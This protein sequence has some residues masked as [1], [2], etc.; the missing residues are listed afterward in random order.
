MKSEGPG[1]GATLSVILP[2][3]SKS[4]QSLETREELVAVVNS[5]LNSREENRPLCS[6][7]KSQRISRQDD[8]YE[9]FAD[10]EPSIQELMRLELPRF[11][12]EVSICLDGATAL[13]V[14]EQSEFD[15]VVVDLDMPGGRT[16]VIRRVRELFGH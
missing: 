3:S 7:K 6:V 13:A 12:H 4:C 10:D 16:D 14:L 11:G 1:C 15:C 2:V 8:R 5:E 9:W